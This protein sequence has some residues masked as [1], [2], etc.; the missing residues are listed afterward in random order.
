M[1][2]YGLHWRRERLFRQ[3][4]DGRSKTGAEAGLARKADAIERECASPAC[5]PSGTKSTGVAR[6]RG[7]S[8]KIAR[9]LVRE[10]DLLE[11]RFGPA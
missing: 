4:I 5:A 8:D 6:A 11:A 10:I 2:T 9:K 7:A 3:R 1:E